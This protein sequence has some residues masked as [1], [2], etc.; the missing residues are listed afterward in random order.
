M[1]RLYVMCQ[2]NVNT[3]CKDKITIIEIF[4]M[5]HFSVLKIIFLFQVNIE[6][7]FNEKKYTLD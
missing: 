1:E 6:I 7:K 5:F 4:I 3:V 2:Y